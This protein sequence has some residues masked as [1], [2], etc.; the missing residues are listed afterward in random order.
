MHI[1][2]KNLSSDAIVDLLVERGLALSRLPPEESRG[3]LA[4][5]VRALKC[6]AECPHM[7]ARLQLL[8]ADALRDLANVDPHRTKNNLRGQQRAEKVLKSLL[9]RLPVKVDKTQ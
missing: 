5:Q 6:L 8:L 9:K 1:D 4:A 7:P 2:V 3:T